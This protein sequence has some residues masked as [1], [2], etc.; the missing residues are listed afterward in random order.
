[1]TDIAVYAGSFDPFTNGHMDVVK[2]AARLFA[3]L[4]VVI[5]TNTEKPRAFDA[6]QM[7]GAI[8][9]SIADAGIG[10]CTVCIHTG[11]TADFAEQVG[12]SYLVRGLRN[13]LDYSYEENLAAVNR[14]LCKTLDTVYFR[15]EN[16]ALSA[17]MV[18]E[19]CRYGGVRR[20]AP[21]VPAPVFALLEAA[22]K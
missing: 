11:L 6:A 10:N 12:A 5:A 17:T 8:E 19:L 7:R 18:R 16:A 4:Y 14:A 1:M 9:R 3:H 2:K 13:S 21:Y 22:A 15:A 20:A